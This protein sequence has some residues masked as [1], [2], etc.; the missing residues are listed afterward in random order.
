[1]LLALAVPTAAGAGAGG[2]GNGNAYGR[3]GVK[4]VP[5]NVKFKASKAKKKELVETGI[6]LGAE[7]A[8]AATAESKTPPVG[9]VRP[10]VAIDFNTSG[11][12]LTNATLRGVGKNIEVWVQNNRAFPAGDCRNANPADVAITDD[13]VQS[14]ITAFDTRM[15]PTE[16]SLFSVPPDRDGANSQL[17]FDYSGDGDKIVT[18]VMNIRDE[19]YV[20]LNNANGLGYVVGYFSSTVTDYHDRNTMTIDAFDW[21]HRSGANPPDDPITGP[22]EACTSRPSFPY[23]MESTFAH[24][25]QHLLEYYASPGELSWVNEGLSDYAMR[26]TG[27]ARPEIPQGQIG[28]EGH[29]QCFLGNLGS[30]IAGV[31]HGGAE[32][33]LT[34]WGDQ[35][36]NREIL[37][38]YG[39]AWSFMDYL[40]GQFGQAFMTALH[41][42][43]ANGLAGLQ[44]VL[45]RFLTG[46]KAQDV[47]H[48]WLAAIALDNALDTQKVKGATRES[49]YQI[50][51][52][53]TAV[54][55]ANDQSYSTPG[56]PPNGG[57][58]VRLRDAAGA[59]LSAAQ[60]QSLSFSGQRQFDPDPLGGKV[61]DGALSA[62]LTGNLL[63]RTLAREVTV[64]GANPTLTFK[65]KYDLE[66]HWDYGFVQVSTD[67]GKTY[68]SLACSNTNSD[69]VPDAHPLVVANVPGYSGLQPTFR[70]ETCDL[71]AYAGKTVV[72][73]FRGVT[74]WGTIG[75]DD[76]TS[77]DG[78]FVDDITLGGTLLSDGT[79]L[80]GWKS[81]TQVY[82]TRVA[83]WT[84]QLV[85]YR[86]D[87]TAPT[88]V[89]SVPV[90]PDFTGSL[91]RGKLRRI[92][93]DDADVVGAI[94]TY[95]EPTE[96]IEKYAR[97]ELR[98][99]GTLQPGG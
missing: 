54:N 4:P 97:Y 57:D 42:E 83:G 18:L 64:P 17:P 84:I 63:N 43:D 3:D 73:M 87:G 56:A 67:A 13:Q 99:N 46:R 24:E 8:T 2:G 52:L 6:A 40:E 96:S 35:G 32:N 53:A 37:C 5:P 85:G 90:G 9:T 60:V 26:K 34:W 41:N 98:V 47:V 44:A 45:D 95:D 78:W 22:A 25:Y 20:D 48:Q 50:P 72:L 11:P 30:T 65:G 12:F 69:N 28:S 80:D 31:P 21:I 94:V 61:V 16:S 51:T 19:N 27:F 74:D 82:P 86:T 49:L 36:G 89:G 66:E 81:E 79:S 55:W 7:A 77:N 59:P 39:A 75:N 15:Y 62:D 33:S 71:S 1:M 92:I 93:G 38:D 88:F 68:T 58:F 10:F 23:R 76:D 29:I 14:L 70:T 91:D